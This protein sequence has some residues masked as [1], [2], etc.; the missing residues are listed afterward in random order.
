[1]LF[2][3]LLGFLRLRV[4][5]LLHDLHGHQLE[6]IVGVSQHLHTNEAKEF[7]VRES[8]AT[9]LLPYRYMSVLS[10]NISIITYGAYINYGWQ[11]CWNS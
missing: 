1:M 6:H 3:L 4:A 10:V 5:L 9:I 2:L 7:P 11:V 8:K